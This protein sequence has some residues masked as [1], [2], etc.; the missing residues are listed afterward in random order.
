M[1]VRVAV[2]TAVLLVW[3]NAAVGI[4]G[5]GPINLLYFGVLAAGLLGALIVRLEPQGMSRV[6]FAMAFAQAL[7]PVIALIMR[8]PDFAPGVPQVFCLNAVFVILWIGS[9]LL[10]R[11]SN[12]I[13][14]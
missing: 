11:R 13:H 14:S 8:E 12:T 1:A 2:I 3:I 9:A 7:V 4:I 10:F 6:L 5:Q